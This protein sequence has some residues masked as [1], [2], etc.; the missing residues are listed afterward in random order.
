MF[1]DSLFKKI[2]DKTNINKDTIL[3]IANKLQNSNM[4]DKDVLNDLINNLTSLTGKTLSDEKR[5]K[6]INTIIDDKVPKNMDNM[7]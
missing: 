2:E 7:L 6:I 4:K 3:S 1:K 5:E